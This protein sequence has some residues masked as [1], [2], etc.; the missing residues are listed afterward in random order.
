MRRV[1]LIVSFVVLVVSCSSVLAQWSILDDD[2]RAKNPGHLFHPFKKADWD[3]SNFASEK[4]LKWFKDA[5]YGM[6][7][8]FGLSTYKNSDLS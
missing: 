3:K 6:F 2:P 7:V 1:R 5:K 4:E 8:H